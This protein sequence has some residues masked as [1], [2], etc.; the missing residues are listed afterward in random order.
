MLAALAD[1]ITISVGG[2]TWVISMSVIM[3]IIIAAVIGVIAEFIVG[4]RVPFGIV[5]AVI[6]GMIGIWLLTSVIKIN[7]FADIDF[8][9]VPLIRALIGAIIFIAL[10]HAITGGFRPRRRRYGAAS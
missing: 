9:G 6:A 2:N 5:G 3:Y 10:W 4:W 8:D 7:G 1:N